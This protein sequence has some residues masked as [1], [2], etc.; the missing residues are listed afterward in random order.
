MTR[1]KPVGYKVLVLPNSDA[2]PQEVNGIQLGGNAGI[3]EGTVAG[4][5]SKALEDTFKVGDKVLYI[6]KAGR[7]RVSEGKIHVLL[8]VTDIEA[9][10]EE[11]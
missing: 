1:I 11:I 9:I 7:E 4:S 6:T 5:V 10:L 2:K 3:S 8:D